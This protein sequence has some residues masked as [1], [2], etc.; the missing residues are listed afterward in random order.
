MLLRRSDQAGPEA[1]ASEKDS[2][3]LHPEDKATILVADDRPQDREYLTTLLEGSGYEV[4]EAAEGAAALRIIRERQPDLI[5]TDALMPKMD[6]FELI[7]RIREDGATK[8]IPIVLCTA[9]Y[10]DEAARSLIALCPGAVILPKPLEPKRLLQTVAQLLSSSDAVS[11]AISADFERLHLQLLAN[12]IHQ[13]EKEGTL[14]SMQPRPVGTERRVEEATLT[15]VLFV[16]TEETCQFANGAASEWLGLDAEDLVGR[17]L[18]QVL[19]S[20]TYE[21]ICPF[22]RRALSGEKVLINMERDHSVDARQI[23]STFIPDIT[24]AG[25]V[26]GVLILQEAVGG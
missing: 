10:D 9:S 3:A 4:W 11:S 5:I 25:S 13:Y 6:G 1:D 18:A 12:R 2:S 17:T 14:T 8:D 20:E 19:G 24:K 16:D 7:R 15:F 22:L 26:R 23:R 21:R